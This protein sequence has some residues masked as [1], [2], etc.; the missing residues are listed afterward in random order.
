M[1]EVPSAAEVLLSELEAGGQLVDEGAFT[2]DSVR[3]LEKLRS[4]QLADANA[5][6]LLLVE[7][8]V[9]GGQD[10]VRV[11]LRA[12]D[13]GIGLGPIVFAAEELEQLFVAVFSKLDAIADASERRRR[14]ALQKLAIA[15]NA[16]LGLS[17][18]L[19]TVESGGHRLRLSPDQPT[20][21]V[22]PIAPAVVGTRVI[23]DHG[24]L[25]ATGKPPEAALLRSHCAWS[26]TP[27]M[28]GEQT[29]S[30]GLSSA[31]QPP[32]SHEF[33]PAP[34]KVGKV[35]LDG[36]SIGLAGL[37]YEGDAAEVTFLCNGVLA[38]RIQI[39]DAERPAAREFVAIVD[40]DLPKDLG[41]AKLLRG[42]EF[43]RVMDAI[44]VV[45]DRIA[46]PGYAD[47]PQ[48]PALPKVRGGRSHAI[49]FVL[50]A[51]GILAIIVGHGIVAWLGLLALPLGVAIVMAGREAHVDS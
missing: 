33:I 1:S 11:E 25:D 15:C 22:E 2:I 6:V 32:L 7:A 40:V 29:I 50:W 16:A 8:A 17:P 36:E 3:A 46:P 19:I 10:P 21:T 37:R 12:G 34:R 31:L 18:K 39:G 13:V 51:G 26:P 30:G 9:L 48:R 47:A 24:L 35:L 23:V 41:Q 42:P 27:I 14:R 20:G 49:A 43:E 5:Y 44:W 28:I 4:Y 45:H 38:E